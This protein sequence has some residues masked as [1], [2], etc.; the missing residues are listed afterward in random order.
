MFDGGRGTTCRNLV[1]LYMM[2]VFKD[3]RP[4][5]S[6]G[7]DIRM[8]H[9]RQ[10]EETEKASLILEEHLLCLVL[11]GHKTVWHP[12]GKLEISPG[13]GFFLARGNYLRSERRT[14]P[15][16][17]YQSLVISLSDVWLSSLA[18][19]LRIFEVTGSNVDGVREDGETMAGRQAFH[20]LEDV[21]VAGLVQQL[22]QYFQLPGEQRRI[23]Q[24]LPM[25]IRELLLV[26]L[27]AGPNRGF[28]A[29]IGGL[30]S[31]RE[32]SLAALMEAHFRESL[33]L[34]QWAFLAG[35]SLASFKRK[36]DAVFHM[37]PRR[38]IQQR[39]LEEAYRLLVDQRKNVTEVAF[40]VGFEN[41]AHFVAS[42]KE[43]YHV[44][45]KQR[46]RREGIYT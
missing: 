25:K 43:R 33:T 9:Y 13:E 40:E 28:D 1:F 3:G 34:E 35:M 24:L 42:F 22:V 41:L 19:D 27:S 6:S 32:P 29:V 45:P 16:L 39:R 30:P 8:I 20:L 23:E 18:K 12:Q 46:Q 26:L 36:F 14:D 37:P 15:L 11:C 21:L 31:Q 4:V 38:W 2:D 44:T 10:E 7:E 17:G 5:L